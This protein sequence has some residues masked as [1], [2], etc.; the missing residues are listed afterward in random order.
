MRPLKQQMGM[1]PAFLTEQA[2]PF[3]FVGCDYT[4][5]FEVKLSIRRN[6]PTTKAYI[7]LFVCLS[8]KAIHLEL[9]SDMTTAE[10]IMSFENFIARRGI[11]IILYSDNGTN[12]IGAVKEIDTLFNQM[13]SQ[14]NAFTRLLASRNIQFKNMPPR[15]S[16][17][18]GIWE[19]QV[20]SVKYHLRRVLGDTKL[21][22]KQ[23][24]YVLKQI[25]ACI[26]S[27]PLW[28]VSPDGDDIEVLTP[29]H[30]FNFQAINT[31]P[32]PD[33]TH[34]PLNRLDQ[35]QYL[36]RLYSDFWK[37]WSNEYLHQLQPRTKWTDKKPNLQV[38]NIV[39]IADDNVPPSRWLAGRVVNTHPGADGLVRVAEVRVSSGA[40]FKRPIHK[41]GLLPLPDND[42][43]EPT[44]QRG[45]NVKY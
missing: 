23:F 11:P 10:F 26:N 8:T 21:T 12:F 25:E 42:L 33:L 2:R 13:V 14:N 15:A 6:S 24:D 9:A 29:S 1:L 36:Y 20:A 30:F 45:E 37:S 39:L 34:I 3:A 35:Y 32:R 4:G 31:L 16:H 43:V 38:G 40:I 17:M 5:H 7:A 41:L 19:R 28:A 44:V 27:R 18:A 22:A